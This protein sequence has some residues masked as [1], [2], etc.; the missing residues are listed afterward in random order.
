MRCASR[1]PCSP[2]MVKKPRFGSTSFV[3]AKAPPPANCLASQ[4]KFSTCQA[5]V[6]AS[7]TGFGLKGHIPSTCDI[8]GEYAQQNCSKINAVKNEDSESFCG[9]SRK[10][11]LGPAFLRVSVSCSL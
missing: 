2:S 3:S 10:G 6:E 4:L 7:T 8:R 5:A 11:C 1:S 9:T